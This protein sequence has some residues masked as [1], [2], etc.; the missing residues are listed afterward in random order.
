MDNTRESRPS[1]HGRAVKH[2][3]LQRLWQHTQGSAS[4]RALELEAKVNIHNLICNTEASFSDRNLK[5]KGSFL[6]WSLTGRTNSS[7]TDPSPGVDDHHKINSMALGGSFSHDV[8]SGQFLS[9]C[10]F[11]FALFYLIGLLLHVS[12]SFQSLWEEFLSV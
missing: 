12:F 7:E 10:V 6:Q 8:K 5:M 9:G 1:R 2:G 4:D 3:N 11:C